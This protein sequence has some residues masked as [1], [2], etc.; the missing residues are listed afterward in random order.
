[1]SS[2]TRNSLCENF[3]TAKVTTLD[4]LH[5]LG[6]LYGRRQVKFAWTA[7]NIEPDLGYG[8]EV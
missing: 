8:N 6:V 3:S 2:G 1:M 4:D 5:K 7:V